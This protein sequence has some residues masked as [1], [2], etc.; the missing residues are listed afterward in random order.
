MKHYFAF[1]SANLDN[2]FSGKSQTSFRFAG[3]G[4]D[5]CAIGRLFDE[6]G[7]IGMMLI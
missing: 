1:L 3:C 4:N 7:D 5:V 2:D 6:L